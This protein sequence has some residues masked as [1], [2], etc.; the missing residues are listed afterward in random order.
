[1]SAEFKFEATLGAAQLLVDTLT[2]YKQ[3]CENAGRPVEYINPET[4]EKIYSATVDINKLQIEL[5]ERT[6]VSR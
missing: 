1:M 4:R 5:F 3:Q 6:G 2:A